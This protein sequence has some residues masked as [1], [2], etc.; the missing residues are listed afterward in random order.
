MIKDNTIM[1]NVSFFSCC[2]EAVIASLENS[3]HSVSLNFNAPSSLEAFLVSAK[4]ELILPS[5]EF[6]CY[7]VS[8]S[9]VALNSTEYFIF[10]LRAETLIYTSVSCLHYAA[11]GFTH[12]SCSIIID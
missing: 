8:N 3:N 6:P 1:L 11:L 7:F 2:V 5:S 10:S 12:S 4:E 9:L